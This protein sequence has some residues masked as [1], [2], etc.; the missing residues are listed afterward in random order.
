[1]PTAYQVLSAIVLLAI[2]AS[3]LTFCVVEHYRI[4]KKTSDSKYNFWLRI[5]N[6]EFYLLG[7]CYPIKAVIGVVLHHIEVVDIIWGIIWLM[8]AGM[9]FKKYRFGTTPL[10]KEH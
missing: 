3:M 9:V 2:P 10:V 7:V 1:M 8:L 5:R 6:L 4:S